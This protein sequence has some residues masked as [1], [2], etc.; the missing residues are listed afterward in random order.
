MPVAIHIHAKENIEFT[1]VDHFARKSTLGY[2]KFDPAMP[3]PLKKQ[4]Q[5]KAR[6]VLMNERKRF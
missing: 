3:C 2:A 4:G 5:I 1:T 6:H